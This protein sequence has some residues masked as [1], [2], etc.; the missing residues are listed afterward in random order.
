VCEISRN[1]VVDSMR[2]VESS[3]F[4]VK[5]IT[6]NAK[7]NKRRQ[8]WIHEIYHGSRDTTRLSFGPGLM[9]RYPNLENP[10]SAKG[11]TDFTTA[12]AHN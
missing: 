2:M 6:L 11:S 4:L 8:T 9:T 7:V 12:D 5:E 3:G 10:V 1:D